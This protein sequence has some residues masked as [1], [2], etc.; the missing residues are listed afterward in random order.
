MAMKKRNILILPALIVLAI[1]GY[2]TYKKSTEY[3]KQL[4]NEIAQK[5]LEYNLITQEIDDN[6]IYEK[7]WDSIK[8]F[9]DELPGDRMNNY[10]DF[11]I[12]LETERNFDLQ[13]TPE[14]V[15]IIDNEEMQEIVFKLQFS[16]TITDLAEFLGRLDGEQDK[17]LQ[18]KSMIVNYRGKT[19]RPGYSIFDKNEDKELAVNLVLATPAKATQAEETEITYGGAIL[20]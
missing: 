12:N 4:D 2:S 16:S 9:M 10:G 13:S 17:L 14:E 20:P 5:S 18:I 15:P 8:A 19:F 3:L 1:V 6:K 7:K 11:L